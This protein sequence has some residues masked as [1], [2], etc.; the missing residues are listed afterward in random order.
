MS[1]DR[2]LVRVLGPGNK[3]WAGRPLRVELHRP[4]VKPVVFS[5]TTGEVEV[6]SRL[7]SD[8][9]RA[10]DTDARGRA[11]HALPHAARA[12]VHAAVR[13]PRQVDA[14]SPHSPEGPRPAEG[15][16]DG[17]EASAHAFVD[18]W[19]DRSDDSLDLHPAR[20][21]WWI[22]VWEDQPGGRKLAHAEQ[23]VDRRGPPPRRP[24]AALR[25]RVL[26]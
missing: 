10:A 20:T 23:V 1:E 13:A 24:R 25:R 2:V 21:R 11:R 22:E 7:V 9:P 4:L 5:T 18:K 8:E 19:H 6:P 16:P 14:H 17:F 26:C 15:L 12:Y 3:P